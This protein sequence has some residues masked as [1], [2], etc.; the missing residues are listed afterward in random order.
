MTRLHDAADPRIG[1]LVEELAQ[2]R[3]ETL[4]FL[5]WSGSLPPGDEAEAVNLLFREPWWLFNGGGDL[6]E[7]DEDWA[8]DLLTW[9][10]G[11]TLAYDVKL[12]PDAT[13][14][15]LASRFLDLLPN[16]RRWFSNGSE[17]GEGRQPRP[18]PWDP[19]T[20]RTAPLSEKQSISRSLAK[21]RCA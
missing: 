14:A 17:R 18:S 10:F 15:E 1:Q 4:P 2:A 20:E 3:G 9:L 11:H 6:D 13:A 21:R 19:L 12:M 7:I 5:V 8:V 16:E